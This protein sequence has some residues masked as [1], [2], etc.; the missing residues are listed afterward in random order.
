MAVADE[1]V[2]V[3]PWDS[4]GAEVLT[5]SEPPQAVTATYR[6]VFVVLAYLSNN[7]CLAHFPGAKGYE[8]D[9]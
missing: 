3:W 1:E 7:P 8:I 6:P 9:G 2:V 4:V 5:E